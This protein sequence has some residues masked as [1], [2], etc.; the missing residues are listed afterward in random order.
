VPDPL[1]Y[2]TTLPLRWRDIDV[3]GHLNQSVYHELLEEARAGLLTELVR[4]VG[5]ERMTGGLVVRHV[6]LDYHHEVRKDHGKVQVAAW[7]VRVGTSSIHL[8]QE[9]RLPDGTLS[10]SGTAVLVGW[11]PATR[12]KRALS[13]LE[14]EALGAGGAEPPRA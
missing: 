5:A 14:R 3:L 4:R 1:R 2:A 12:G 11:D 13:D 6:D 7:V 8:G 9:L 10:A